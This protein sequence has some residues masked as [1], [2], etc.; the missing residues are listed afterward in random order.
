MSC[1]R[2]RNE[3]HPSGILGLG[4]RDVP[5]SRDGVLTRKGHGPTSNSHRACRRHRRS[6][7]DLDEPGGR[8]RHD[9][10][11]AWGAGPR[12]GSGRG[13]NSMYTR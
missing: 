2:Q 3:L 13:G 10:I 6:S 9:Q 1:R 5:G 11:E 8:T 7:T 12:V 4:R